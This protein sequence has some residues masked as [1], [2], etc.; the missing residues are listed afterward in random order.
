MILEEGTLVFRINSNLNVGGR[1][2]RMGEVKQVQRITHSHYRN[3]IISGVITTDELW[4]DIRNI[5][6]LE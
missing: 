3:E 6:I 1:S 5:E 2:W 4:S